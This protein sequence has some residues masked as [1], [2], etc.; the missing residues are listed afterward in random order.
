VR[1]TADSLTFIPPFSPEAVGPYRTSSNTSQPV[2][3]FSLV[4]AWLTFEHKR[5]SCHIEVVCSLFHLRYILTMCT[6]LFSGYKLLFTCSCIIGPLE[7]TVWSVT[8]NFLLILLCF[9]W[10][11]FSCLW[12]SF[13]WLPFLTTIF[14]KTMYILILA[15][16]NGIIL[17]TQD[18]FMFILSTPLS[19]ILSISII[20]S[21]LLAVLYVEVCG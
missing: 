4:H 17:I 8:L 10:F 7:Q 18:W 20:S 5:M 21:V 6:H 9:Q 13:H 1:H 3:N 19:F 11:A 16:I 15:N 2:S 14:D 12:V